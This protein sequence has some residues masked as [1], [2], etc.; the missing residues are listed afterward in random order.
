MTSNFIMEYNEIQY[1]YISRHI[2]PQQSQNSK[3]NQGSILKQARIKDNDSFVL[4]F[5]VSW[6]TYYS[7]FI[8]LYSDHSSDTKL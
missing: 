1:I 7:V 2:P 4:Y 6:Y 3:K 5:D 8:L